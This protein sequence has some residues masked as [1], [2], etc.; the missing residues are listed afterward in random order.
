MTERILTVFKSKSSLANEVA[1]TLSQ[2][3]GDIELVSVYS[4][5]DAKQ[6]LKTNPG[7]DLVITHINIPV[8]GDNTDPN[9][10]Q[11]LELLQFI[12]TN[13]WHL[14]KIMIV[15]TST[16]DILSETN[17]IP[18]TYVLDLSDKCEHWQDE[19]ARHAREFLLLR[20]HPYP[21]E[22]KIRTVH[23]DI[24][25]SAEN[26]PNQCWEV[27]F[28]VEGGKPT[29]PKPVMI[30][31]D[32]RS[33][34]ELIHFSKILPKLAKDH[35][36]W[37]Y[38]LQIIGEKLKNILLSDT[39]IHEIYYP[40]LDQLERDFKKLKIR[41]MVKPSAHP[42][43]LEA[44][45]ECQ[46]D[47]SWDYWM[48]KSPIYRQLMTR[49]ALPYYE[50]PLF[51]DHRRANCLI[52]KS[53][54]E[55]GRNYVEKIGRELDPL[56]K[57]HDEANELRNFLKGKPWTGEVEILPENGGCCSSAM[58]EEWLTQKGPWHIV[59]YAGHSFCN[60]KGYLVFSGVNQPETTDSQTFS[61]W[62]RAAKTRFLYL[63]SC[64]S[65]GAEFLYEIADYGI[66][67][68]LGFRWEVNDNSAS[69]HTRI[70][71]EKLSECRCLDHAFLHTRRAMHDEY[72]NEVTWAAPVLV[73]QI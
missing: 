5:K 36:L 59:H 17:E 44:L 47:D 46:D 20:Q 34:K 22:E 61:A 4:A 49:S 30:E 8:D 52:I 25:V 28:R 43:V 62:L 38:L 69:A 35:D 21:A 51:K 31:V 42:V 32:S 39:K 9:E 1:R 12:Y 72:A 48:L 50:P 58:V 6:E 37:E 53:D 54:M 66:P 55:V 57:I 26:K 60:G 71:Y 45:A 56:D 27:K 63:S 7:Y 11:G 13:G 18:W 24:S 73:M 41:F 33:V 68:A 29:D 40:L 67:S 23:M 14:P 65:S 2:E 64:H 3:L 10:Q 16:A 15:P 70:F 19:V